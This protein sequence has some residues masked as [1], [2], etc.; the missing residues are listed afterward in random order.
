MG[1][2]AENLICVGL[3]LFVYIWAEATSVVGLRIEL[4]N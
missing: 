2:L 1:V 4:L 3:Y